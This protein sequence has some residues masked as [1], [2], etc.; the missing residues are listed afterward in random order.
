MRITRYPH[1]TPDQFYGCVAAFIDALTGELNAASAALRRLQGTAKGGAFAY[2]IALDQH[3][4][5]ALIVLDRWSTVTS[6]FEPHLALPRRPD[7][8]ARAQDRV[9]DAGQ[10]LQRANELLDAADSYSPAI[11][12]ACLM[13]WQSLQATFTEERSEAGDAAKL[14]PML[15]DEYREARRIFSED[16]AAR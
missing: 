1:L 4:Y 7:L 12:E 15:P 6:A 9:K 13:A 8:A 10:V 2:E 11:V 14:G 3:R 16:L 5:G